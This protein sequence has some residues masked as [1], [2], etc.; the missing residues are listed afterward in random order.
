MRYIEFLRRVL[1]PL[2]MLGKAVP[3][4]SLAST[5]G[6]FT[7]SA[8]R[9]EKAVLYFYPKDNTPGCTA[10]GSDFRDL[11]GEFRRAGARI[12]G[13]SRDSAASHERFKEKMRFPF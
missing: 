1:R 6:S 7:L 3:D 9:G 11:H 5:G 4:F 12:F 13:I 2:E 8:V 10:E